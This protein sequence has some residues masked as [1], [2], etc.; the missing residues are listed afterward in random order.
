MRNKQNSGRNAFTG[1]SDL[2]VTVLGVAL[3]FILAPLAYHA[4][5]E[6]ALT[7]AADNYGSGWDWLVKLGCGLGVGLL[8][9][10]LTTMAFAVT[11]RLGVAKLTTLIFRN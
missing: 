5:I 6:T 9:F 10:G 7:Y 8:T 11:L 1:G 4:S 2:S 3:T